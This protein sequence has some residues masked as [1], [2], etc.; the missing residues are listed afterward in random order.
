MQHVA[1]SF[2]DEIAV[3][4]LMG[5]GGGCPNARYHAGSDFGSVIAPLIVNVGEN[6]SGGFV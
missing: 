1:L 5:G 4:L 6:V 2:F 3:T